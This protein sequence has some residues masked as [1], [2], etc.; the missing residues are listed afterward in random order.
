MLW[1]LPLGQRLYRAYTEGREA[2]KEQHPGDQGLRLTK[3]IVNKTKPLL[4]QREC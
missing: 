3:R 2:E 4:L 1:A